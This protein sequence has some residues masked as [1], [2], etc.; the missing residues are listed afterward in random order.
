[1][2]NLGAV[3]TQSSPQVHGEQWIAVNGLNYSGGGGGGGLGGARKGSYLEQNS[4]VIVISVEHGLI[5]YTSAGT[6]A[7]SRNELNILFAT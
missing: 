4:P 7:L 1:M 2:E 3:T 6:S 5:S